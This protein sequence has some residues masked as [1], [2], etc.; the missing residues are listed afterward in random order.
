MDLNQVII[1]HRTICE[2]AT[3]FKIYDALEQSRLLLKGIP[4]AELLTELET[5]ED[6]YSN[7]LSYSMK[8]INDPQRNMILNSLVVKIVELADKIKEYYLEK[9]N[10][11]LQHLKHNAFNKLA[12]VQKKFTETLE[13]AQYQNNLADL[14]QDSKIAVPNA[15]AIQKH[16]DF[17]FDLFEYILYCDKLTD[18]DCSF[19][20]AVFNQENT[21]W[22]EQ[23]L[24]T[25]AVTLSMIRFFDTQKLDLLFTFFESG[26]HQVKQRALVGI[27][28]LFYVYDDRIRYYKALNDKVQKIYA[29]NEISDTDVIIIIKQFVKAKDTEKISRRLRD[30][31]IPDIQKLTPLIEDKLGIKNM[32]DD[33]TFEDKN[34]DW[35]SI[36]EG[37][38]E[39]LNKLEELSKLQLEGNDVFMSAFSM[40]KQF[41]FFD[42]IS[43]WFMPFYKEHPETSSILDTEEEK[44]KEVFSSSLERS[45]YMCNSDKFSFM[46]NLKTMPEQQKSMLL[47]LFNAELESVNELAD[48]DEMLNM[49]IKNQTVFTQYIQDLYRF[50]KLHP[51]RNDFD[52]IFQMK[53]DFHNKKFVQT[54][55]P[56]TSFIKQLADFYFK[57]DHYKEAADVFQRILS[58]EK[59]D[60][61]LLQKIGYCFQRSE[62]YQKALEYY[63]KAELFDSTQSWC[64]KKIAFCYHQLKNYKKALEYYLEVE[65]LEPSN[66]SIQVNIANCYLYLKD[67]KKALH[68]FYKIEFNTN[69][70][71]G[72]CR[73]IAWC[74]F[75]LGDFDKAEEY[76]L[77]LIDDGNNYDFMNYG[78]LQF[79]KGMLEIA[80]EYYVKSIHYKTN[81]W[82]L[83]IRGFMDDTEH[84][85][86]HGI[87]HQEIQLML[88]YVKY[89]IG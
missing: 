44:F 29:R 55:F 48:E 58:S 71:T 3:A 43:N 17:R 12:L 66:R 89:K 60:L 25:S 70:I 45:T 24:I 4:I 61:D 52:D 86:K 74:L 77:K 35:E 73:P 65:K 15:E 80:A 36:L 18:S 72:I 62:Q 9:N 88:D 39:L 50:Y 41:S 85:K 23:S 33:E 51:Q 87:S 79:V 22:Y 28:L 83:F 68:Y 40:L 2:N 1:Q 67:Y 81:S 78:H 19:I 38:P 31:I 46:L 14:L 32:M 34:P 5:T 26:I 13:N 8:G 57:T 21:E 7:L 82:E 42:H 30:E 75:V 84:L 54:I 47:S 59:E 16:E 27:V 20:Q 6:T 53:L 11:S 56:D 63:H 49:A 64:L 37:S 10:L 76:L 69:D